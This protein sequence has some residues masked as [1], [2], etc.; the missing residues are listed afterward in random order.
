M[1]RIEWWH[2]AVAA[3][4]IWNARDLAAAWLNAPYERG[5]WLCLTLWLAPVVLAR[6]RSS[7]A[8]PRTWPLVAAL[9]LSLA[10]A[11]ASANVLNDAALAFAAAAWA[12]PDRRQTVWMASAVLWMP[13]AGWLAH[14]IDPLPLLAIRIVLSALASAWYAGAIRRR[15][16]E[17]SVP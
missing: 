1:K 10:G 11:A 12:P 15:I 8:G 2:A 7:G 14:G 9:A 17:R 6:P 4:C 16:V 5:A 3:Y 13:V